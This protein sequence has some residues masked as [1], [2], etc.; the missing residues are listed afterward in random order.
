MDYQ[1]LLLLHLL[2]GGY[3]LGGD[4]GVFYIAG[5][6]ADPAQPLPV[7]LFSAKA[8][9]LLDMIPRTCLIMA[10]GTGLTVATQAGL[11]PLHGWLW[12]VWLVTLGWL[13]LAWAAFVKEHSAAGHRIARVDFYVRLVVL[14][15]CVAAGVDAFSDGGLI[16]QSRW[17]GAKLVLFAGIIS[18]G[19]LVR[20]QLRPFGPLFGKV[21][22]NTATDAE[23]LALKQLVARVKIPV[24]CIWM[25][26]LAIMALGKLKPF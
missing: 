13:A 16:A 23:Q 12:L 19:L 17:L 6:I 14:A 10:F 4:L 7:R 11:L 24:L 22:S 26:I 2:I 9:M 1:L 25:I 18:M 5:K 20:I 15:G 21:V 3:W 8:M